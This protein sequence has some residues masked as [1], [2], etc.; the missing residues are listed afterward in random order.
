VSKPAAEPP[1]PRPWRAPGYARFYCAAL[2]ARTSNEMFPVAV[3]L[4]ILDRTGSAGLAG[5]AVAAFT[6]PSVVTGPVLGAWLDRSRHPVRAI[7]IDQAVSGAGFVALAFAAEGADWAVL[8]LAALAGVTSPLSAGGFTSL[9]P[10]IVPGRDLDSANR[11]EAAGFNSAVVAGPALAGALAVAGGPFAAVLG[12]GVLKLA[13]LVLV[14]GIPLARRSPPAA[15][16]SILQTALA[17]I[18]HV[19]RTPPL[20]AITV[21]GGIALGGRGLLTLAFPFFAAEELGVTRD[22]SA[23]LWTAFA[24]GSAVGVFALARLYARLAPEHAALRGIAWAGLVMLLWPLADAPALALA[25][26]ALAGAAYGP[27]LAATF[28]V[29]Q[30]W[31]PP[32]LHGQVFTTSASLKPG[33]FAIGAAAAGPL[34][35]ELGAPGTLLVAAA[36]QIL[37]FGAGT[38]LLHLRQAPEPARA[39]S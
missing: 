1:H 15:E 32:G 38:L 11:L 29:R 33:S 25:L 12:Q 4:L 39:R 28:G 2:L 26:V 3:V 19:V 8:I 21:A 9:L 34:V 13:A 5:A 14:L 36:L 22:F 24:A 37:A 16:P 7:A 31:T 35:V 23:Y 20:L 30:R 10:S 18:R 17:G 27:G 6:L